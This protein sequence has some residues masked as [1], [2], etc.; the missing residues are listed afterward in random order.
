MYY[1]KHF[2]YSNLFNAHHTSARLVLLLSSEAKSSRS[3]TSHIASKCWHQD[4]NSAGLAPEFMFITVTPYYI[5]EL[6]S[7]FWLHQKLSK[8]YIIKVAIW[9][10]AEQETMDL[11]IYYYWL[12]S[13]VQMYSMEKQGLSFSLDELVIV[14]KCEVT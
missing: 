9:R 3:L 5:L 8:M 7:I 6:M 1:F 14:G 11:M 10:Q 13:R 2:T 12:G 4:S